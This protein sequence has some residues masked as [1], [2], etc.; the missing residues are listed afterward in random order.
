MSS[1][2]LD[3]ISLCGTLKPSTQGVTLKDMEEAIRKG[4]ARE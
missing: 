3:V 1:K 4:T 2:S